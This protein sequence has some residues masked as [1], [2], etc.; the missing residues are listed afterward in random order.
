[1]LAG[2]DGTVL[3]AELA[4]NEDLVTYIENNDAL[5][6]ARVAGTLMTLPAM[7]V[8]G[9]QALKDIGKLPSEIQEA[10]ALSH[11]AAEASDAQRLR[12]G[13]ISNPSKHPAAV[14]KHLHRANR[15]A[16]QAK[17]QAK[18]AHHASRELSAAKLGTVGSF[19]ATP[20]GA[21][22]MA[23][24]PPDLLLT[25][26][27]KRRDKATLASMLTPEGGMPHGTR[28]DMRVSNISRPIHR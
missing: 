4:G 23:G 6:W 2:I 8:G 16:T 28:F 11:A 22:L 1:M 5:Q 21:S 13:K 18:L 20:A 7:A 10:N 12:A 24:L 27:Q 19:A 26:A 25:E 9:V 14:Q 3:G 15:L 17:A